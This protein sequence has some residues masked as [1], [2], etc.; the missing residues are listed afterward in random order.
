[1]C[2]LC[3]LCICVSEGGSECIVCVVCAFVVCELCG[4]MSIIWALFITM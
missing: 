2:W 1:M 4:C 3:V